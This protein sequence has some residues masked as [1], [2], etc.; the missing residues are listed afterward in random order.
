[1]NLFSLCDASS[2]SPSHSPP[3]SALL[4]P[5]ILHLIFSHL[6]QHDLVSRTSLV[7]QLWRSVSQMLIPGII[8]WKDT[9]SSEDQAL[10][11]SAMRAAHFRTLRIVAQDHRTL[12]CF[13]SG[14]EQH[15]RDAWARFHQE[16][17]GPSAA[18]P[19]DNKTLAE[20]RAMDVKTPWR[21]LVFVGWNCFN[22]RLDS[23]L[24]GNVRF[25]TI[26]ALHVE[27]LTP[28]EFDLS[29]VLN[30][31]SALQEL[32]LEAFIS[33]PYTDGRNAL[34]TWKEREQQL[35]QDPTS[36]RS[37]L[38]LRT[39]ALRQI[40]IDQ[41]TLQTVLA[42]LPLLTSLELRRSVVLQERSSATVANIAALSSFDRTALLSHV[43]Q[44]CPRLI[45]FHLSTP[46][47]I[48]QIQDIAYLSTSFQRLES[49]ALS[50]NGMHLQFL[51][52]PLFTD[53][54]TTL[55]IEGRHF[56]SDRSNNW[57]QVYLC[58]APLLLHLRAQ[59]VP[60]C[61]T[62]FVLK[63]R[64]T[65]QTDAL[66]VHETVHE[67]SLQ[68]DKPVWACRN[69][70]TLHLHIDASRSS[71]AEMDD[72][73]EHRVLFGYLSRVCPRLEEISLYRVRFKPLIQT[74]LCLLW[75]L[76]R[77]RRFKVIY[78]CDWR[79]E[80]QPT[81][82]VE[83]DLE[84]MAL[85]MV[86]MR[87]V[88]PGQRSPLDKAMVPPKAAR[89]SLGG[90]AVRWILGRTAAGTG[91]HE[92]PGIMGVSKVEREKR[93][94]ATVDH[95]HRICR[96]N[97]E[98]SISEELEEMK[99]HA[100]E[101]R[102]QDVPMVEEGRVDVDDRRMRYSKSPECDVQDELLS[103]DVKEMTQLSKV[104]NVLRE[105]QRLVC[106]S[107]STARDVNRCFAWPELESFEVYQIVDR[108]TEKTM[109]KYEDLLQQIRPD[110]GSQEQ[111]MY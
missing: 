103:L 69:L 35:Q 1:M 52:L 2:P 67:G 17:S 24:C 14:I 80:M 108:P 58:Q 9:L 54:L 41:T 33:T 63:P 110:A 106:M 31:L 95:V 73:A 36:A 22:Q 12:L 71:P 37:F 104:E 23:L 83:S 28:G 82:A 72:M 62:N 25:E 7:C 77:L 43:S 8:T 55:E 92:G 60:L 38:R 66:G 78:T 4:L 105:L 5:E 86:D 48:L 44:H 56:I 39:L 98:V 6:A 85:G 32:I 51:S 75:R 30:E 89:Q 19:S 10:F 79:I 3:P 97:F 42:A 40:M 74:G 109:R 65:F 99:K 46:D 61:T 59:R 64:T 102:R 34:V 70:R 111:F 101:L 49:I 96:M 84:W 18:E 90:K 11:F 93:V 87:G 91:E 68:F 100:L 45:H 47:T 81:L 29:C 15:I 53:R 107:A 16:L 13:E 57:L 26:R 50:S 76:Q 27:H 88:L 20:Q 94:Q 21:K